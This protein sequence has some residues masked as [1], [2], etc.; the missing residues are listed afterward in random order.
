MVSAEHERY[1]EFAATEEKKGTTPREIFQK[2]KEEARERINA[3]Q[4][5]LKNLCERAPKR[6][7]EIEINSQINQ[8]LLD[9]LTMKFGENK[10]W[11]NPL[12]KSE[13]S[14]KPLIKTDEKYYCFL[15]PHLTRNVISIVESQMTQEERIKIGYSDIKGSYFELKAI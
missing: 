4:L 13:I 14:L 10:S 12:D 6:C 9:S 3:L 2:Y 7:F 1:I 15:T 5:V 8:R 11:S